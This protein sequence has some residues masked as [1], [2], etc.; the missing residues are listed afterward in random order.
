MLLQCRMKFENDPKV[1]IEL[2]GIKK[3]PSSFPFSFVLFLRRSASYHFLPNPLS[4]NP[5][6]SPYSKS[7]YQR[8]TKLIRADSLTKTIIITFAVQ[9]SDTDTKSW[10][11]LVKAHHLTRL[12]WL[13]NSWITLQVELSKI[14][15]CNRRQIIH[16]LTGLANNYQFIPNNLLKI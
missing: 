9:S 5:F 1:E 2:E 3:M 16:C 14:C 15:R 4:T 8:K 11:H 12:E 7:M 10:E 6:P 13:L